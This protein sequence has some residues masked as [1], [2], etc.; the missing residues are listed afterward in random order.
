MGD[1]TEYE[2]AVSLIGAAGAAQAE[3]APVAIDLDEVLARGIDIRRVGYAEVRGLLESL[4]AKKAE[5]EV[6]TAS[7][8]QMTQ[9]RVE[10]GK[11][12]VGSG[13]SKAARGLG[14]AAG[15]LEKELGGSKAG[16]A[17]ASAARGL[18][19][20]VRSVEDEFREAIKRDVKKVR[21]NGLVMPTLSLQDQL[22][23]LD[24]IEAGLDR[25]V[26]DSGQMKTIIS[27]IAGLG[28]AAEREDAGGMSDDLKGLVALR[29]RK[30]SDIKGKLNIK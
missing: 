18:G 8:Q 22:S 19:R 28:A 10:L 4:E 21:P 14:A 15:L 7:K 5:T 9:K 25:G 17:A 2:K 24:R 29:D 23:E 30:I 1:E 26:F 11:Q 27:E 16:A 3:L 6:E 20:A 12:L 13:V